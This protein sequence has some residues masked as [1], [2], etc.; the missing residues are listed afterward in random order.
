MKVRG[1]NIDDNEKK[2]IQEHMAVVEAANRDS[3][4]RE[5]VE[6]LHDGILQSA[7]AFNVRSMGQW[8]SLMSDDFFGLLRQHDSRALFVLSQYSII[9]HAFHE[10]WWIGSWGQMLL[11]AI[12]KVFPKEEQTRLDWSLSKMERLIEVHYP[13]TEPG[14]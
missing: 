13:D 6:R 5:E 9:L 3:P 7:Q 12:D 14:S 4:Y 8:L 11:V 2:E 1:E 10:H